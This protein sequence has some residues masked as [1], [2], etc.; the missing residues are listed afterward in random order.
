MQMEV[1]H[2]HLK[3]GQLSDKII[4]V[5]DPERGRLLQ[6]RFDSIEC[7]VSNREFLN[8]RFLSGESAFRLFLMELE[9]ITLILFSMSWMRWLTLILPLY[10]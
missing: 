8:Y 1:F 2:L 3:P 4:L 5:G 10:S 9:Q 7:E 6:S